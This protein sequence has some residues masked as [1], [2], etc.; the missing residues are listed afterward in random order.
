MFNCF[1]RAV[2][3]LIGEGRSAVESDELLAENLGILGCKEPD[4]KSVSVPGMSGVDDATL[5]TTWESS[6]MQSTNYHDLDGVASYGSG[7]SRNALG[8]YDHK[9][10][11]YDSSRMQCRPNKH[12]LDGV[13]SYGSGCPQNALGQYDHKNHHYDSSWMPCPPNTLNPYNDSI[14]PCD[15][16]YWDERD[17]FISQSPNCRNHP[18]NVRFNEYILCKYDEYIAFDRDG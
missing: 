15:G 14:V 10:H 1:S 7:C 5:S 8:Q 2:K 11:A 6:W 18:G 9:N 4:S 3:S 17:I 16:C 12:D 13:A